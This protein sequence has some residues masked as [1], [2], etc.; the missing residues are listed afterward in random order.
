MKHIKKWIFKQK[1]INNIFIKKK[2]LDDLVNWKVSKDKIYHKTRKFFQIVGIRVFT[3]L[4]KTTWDQPIMVQNENG[5][6]G[7]I[8]KKFNKEYKYLLQAKLEPG[9]INQLQLSPTV[10][11]TES[12]YKRVHG[13]KK[14]KFL[15]YFIKKKF[16]VKS[17]QSEQGLRYLNKFNTNYLV[18]IKKKLQL[19]KNFK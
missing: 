3:N 16:V 18:D 13:G 9:N 1:K 6:L 15:E 10:Q 11:A 7:I 8:R 4:N 14:T 2:N 19:P 5:I 17:K 12:N